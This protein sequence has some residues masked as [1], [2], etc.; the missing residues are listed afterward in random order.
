M[1]G[2]EQHTS[3]GAGDTAS[4]PCS[5]ARLQATL[6]ERVGIGRRDW[7]IRVFEPRNVQGVRVPGL[8]YGT[9]WKEEKTSGLVLRALRAGFRGIDT[10]NQRRHYFEAAVGE[11]VVAAIDEGTLTRSDLFLQTKFTFVGGQDH[12]LP[13]DP[14]AA[15]A[16]QV[17]QSFESS[18]E[19][20]R[21]PYVDALVL[22]GP[23]RSQGLTDDDWEAW[24]AMEELKRDSRVRLIGVSNI[25]LD[26]LTTLC[27]GATVP[28]A[29]VQNRCYARN[30]WDRSVR[31]FCESRAMVYQ[32]FSLL[33]ANALE[34]GQP[35]VVEMARRRECTIP[36]LIFR[37]AAQVGMVPLTGTTSEAH[38]KEDLAASKLD[39]AEDE[40]RLLEEC[41]LRG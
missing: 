17:Q 33:T 41:G 28:P 38:M 10:A 20:L 3:Q 27:Q 12:R 34:L 40:V 30:G 13:Y 39:I 36:Q 2:S 16:T 21:T 18:L 31:A 25:S 9:A 22:H 24:R 11:A 29:I 19:H 37:F 8:L 14:A 23:S 35:A 7:R 15:I 26:Q 6:G 32:G 5:K 1:A 4:R